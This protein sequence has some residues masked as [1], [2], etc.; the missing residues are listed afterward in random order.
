M[1]GQGVQEGTPRGSR[2]LS[3]EAACLPHA[4]R[5]RGLSGVRT[6]GNVTTEATTCDK[7][8]TCEEQ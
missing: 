6:G 2:L 3:G 5:L 7:S 8:R 4:C 1:T